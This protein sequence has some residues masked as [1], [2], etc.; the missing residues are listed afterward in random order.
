[1][2][3]VEYHVPY[4]SLPDTRKIGARFRCHDDQALPPASQRAGSHQVVHVHYDDARDSQIRAVY[5]V[6]LMHAVP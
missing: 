6:N 3:S 1:M 5:Q 2:V 4:A